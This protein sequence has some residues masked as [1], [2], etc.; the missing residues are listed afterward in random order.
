MGVVTP[1]GNDLKKTWAALK[2]GQ[3]G[4]GPITKFDAS[5]LPVRIAG[6]L[7]GLH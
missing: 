7:K 6:E 4:I 1:L 2:M 5:G 3:S